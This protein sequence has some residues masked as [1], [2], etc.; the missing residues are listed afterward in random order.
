M[1]FGLGHVTK[2]NPK[3]SADWSAGPFN[4]K[5]IS[6]V[7]MQVSMPGLQRYR[8]DVYMIEH[9]RILVIGKLLSL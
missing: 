7:L 8:G 4:P 2:I 6:W 9:I 5:A 3:T 1:F